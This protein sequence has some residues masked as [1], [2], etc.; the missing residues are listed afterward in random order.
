[1]SV[2]KPNKLDLRV[3]AYFNDRNQI[4]VARHSRPIHRLWAIA[5]M[6]PEHFYG[7]G[8]T[9]DEAVQEVLVKLGAFKAKVMAKLGNHLIRLAPGESVAVCLLDSTKE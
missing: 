6:E 4:W 8:D 1:M 7:Y 3:A 9:L 2:N 5:P